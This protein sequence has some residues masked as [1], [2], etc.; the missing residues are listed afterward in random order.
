MVNISINEQYM[1]AGAGRFE[2]CDDKAGKVKWK[3]IL[4]M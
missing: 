2:V 1:G 3:Y 4:N